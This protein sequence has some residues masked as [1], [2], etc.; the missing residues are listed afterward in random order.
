MKSIPLIVIAL[1]FTTSVHAELMGM[2]PGRSARVQSH[3]NASIEAGT[4]WYTNQLQ[5]ST[6]RINVKPSRHLTLYI[7]YAK[8]RASDLP[9][10][11]S[12]QAVFVGNGA[13]GGIMFGIP[14]FFPSLDIAFKAAYHA[15]VIKNKPTPGTQS[16]TNMALHQRQLNADF[17]VSPIDPLFDNGLSWYGTLGFVSTD[18]QTRFGNQQVVI[19]NPIRY[20]KK[21][22]LAFGAGVVR[23]FKYGSFY[24]GMAWLSGDPLLGGGIRYTF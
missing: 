12:E 13:G 3:P 4:N 21:S 5:W 18:A 24:A 1:F 7:D 22:G 8:L 20:R 17:V 6:F 16:R 19:T 15:A 2:V 11:P 14:D 9:V 10:S 23:P